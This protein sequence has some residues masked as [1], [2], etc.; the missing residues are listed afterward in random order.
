MTHAEIEKAASATTAALGVD[1]L[2][3]PATQRS[4]ESPWY[5]VFPIAGERFAIS[6][7]NVDGT[8]QQATSLM[9]AIRNALGA[10]PPTSCGTLLRAADVA[11]R[12]VRAGAG[13]GATGILAIV[14]RVAQTLTYVSAGHPPPFIRYAD[15]TAT[16]L[17]AGAIPIELDQP[18]AEISVDLGDATLVLLYSAG[19][20]SAGGDA[21]TDARRLHDVLADERLRHCASPAAWIARRMLGGRAHDDTAVLAVNFAGDRPRRSDAATECGT[22]PR[23]SASWSF[24]A[25]GPASKGARRAFLTYLRAKGDEGCAVDTTAAELIFGE[26]LGNVVRHAP[27]PVE[28]TLDWNGT[29][30]V[31]HVLD[32]GPGFRSRR[33]RERLP[34][35]ELS[36]SGRGLFIVNACASDFSVRNRAGRGTHASA[37]LPSA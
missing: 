22:R 17:P 28:I 16:A 32:S 24:D 29:V 10:E 13:A 14:D 26:L 5:D 2:H 8:P 7:G 19:L 36:E 18:G 4:R 31:L 1:G 33:S 20:V 15:G 6:V 34:T 3:V 37:T 27:G 35:D 30:P 23:W 11:F 9:L 12:S 25:T 21:D